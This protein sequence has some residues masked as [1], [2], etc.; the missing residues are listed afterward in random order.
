MDKL[1]HALSVCLR[2]CFG[3]GVLDLHAE[4]EMIRLPHPG[5]PQSNFMVFPDKGPVVSNW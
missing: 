4:G 1:K 2:R 3:E 5:K